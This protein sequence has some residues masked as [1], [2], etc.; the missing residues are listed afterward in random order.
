[1]LPYQYFVPTQS[2]TL[3]IDMQPYKMQ[4]SKFNRFFSL[5]PKSAT[6]IRILKPRKLQK[7]SEKVQT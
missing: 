2:S 7:Q 6:E 3:V 5:R 1:M 4:E